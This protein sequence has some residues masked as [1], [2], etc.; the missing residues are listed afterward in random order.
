MELTESII[1]KTLQVNTTAHLLTIKEFLP[2]MISQKRGHIVSIAS[3]AGLTG[4]NRLS[5][6]CASKFGA[7]AI[8]E[9]VRMELQAAGHDFI[10]TTCICPYIIKSPMFDGAKPAFPFQLLN[11]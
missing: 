1:N 8:D 5:D 11:H 4:C 3:M 6:Y 7:V 10:K 9:S 2:G